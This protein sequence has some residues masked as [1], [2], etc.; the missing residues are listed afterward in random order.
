M[1]AWNSSSSVPESA[2]LTQFPQIEEDD[3]P[4]PS[5]SGILSGIVGFFRSSEPNIAA[6]APQAAEPIPPQSV[7]NG[8]AA[9][10]LE[11][12]VRNGIVNGNGG[13]LNCSSETPLRVSLG[14]VG[15]AERNGMDSPSSTISREEVRTGKFTRI[16]SMFKV[17]VAV[18]VV[19]TNTNYHLPVPFLK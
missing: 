5:G 16:T 1:T 15:T 11:V 19:G 18:V 8:I 4:T 14:A 12:D 10:P 7:E 9:E 6:R 3:E 17:I 2:A 13:N